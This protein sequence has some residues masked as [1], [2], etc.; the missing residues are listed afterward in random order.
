MS[1]A[2][3]QHCECGN[4]TYHIKWTLETEPE[5]WVEC[6][7]CGRKINSVGPKI[8]AELD[9]GKANP[10]A[11][12]WIEEVEDAD[13]SDIIIFDEAGGTVENLTEQDE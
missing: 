3:T 12:E 10:T 1:G 2:R 11:G 9:W 6:S 8:E 5:L 13:L 4:D 7:E